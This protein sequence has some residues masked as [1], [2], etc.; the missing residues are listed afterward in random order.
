VS[1]IDPCEN[2]SAW[3]REMPLRW[4]GPRQTDALLQVASPPPAKNHAR[5]NDDRKPSQHIE[6]SVVALSA[7]SIFPRTVISRK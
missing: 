1:K 2:R 5:G 6:T 4:R 3:G 7:M